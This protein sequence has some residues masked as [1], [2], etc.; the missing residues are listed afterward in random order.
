VVMGTRGLSGAKSLI[1]GSVSHYVAQ[2]LRVP[3]FIV[4]PEHNDA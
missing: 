2:H 3:V 4:P 1:L